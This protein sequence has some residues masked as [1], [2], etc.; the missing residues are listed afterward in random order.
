[1][2]SV[3]LHCRKGLELDLRK[4]I[5]VNH[6]ERRERYGIGQREW[7]QYKKD[8]GKGA[9]SDTQQTSVILKKSS[10][11]INSRKHK[12]VV[13]SANTEKSEEI[14]ML[15]VASVMSS[16]HQSQSQTS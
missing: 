4:H 13:S 6:I 9:S 2:K 3:V 7:T 5:R 16:D 1:M 10:K 11:E 15:S 8:S 14:S 12:K